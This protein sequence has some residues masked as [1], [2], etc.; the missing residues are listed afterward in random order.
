MDSHIYQHRKNIAAGI[1]GCYNIRKAEDHE[2]PGYQKQEDEG[3]VTDFD[4]DNSEEDQK[5]KDE[6]MKK[7]A[8]STGNTP[9]KETVTKSYIPDGSF[10]HKGIAAN[11]YKSYTNA[12]EL[13]KGGPGSGRVGK[14]DH[15]KL[16]S[17]DNVAIVAN[18]DHIAQHAGL[19][20][21]DY[22][23]LSAHDKKQHLTKLKVA[24][25]Q[26]KMKKK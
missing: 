6:I 12:D 5:E 7:K 8:M 21:E 23:K 22:K 15:V 19:N 4:E 18:A 16:H 9:G 2:T 10:L 26:E 17:D 25:H 24:M 20:M 11:I 1:Y 14:F 3:D 13:S